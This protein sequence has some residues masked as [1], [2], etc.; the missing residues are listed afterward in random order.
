MSIHTVAIAVVALGTG[1]ALWGAQAPQLPD[2]PGKEQMVAV[3]GR[4]HEAQ[5]SASLRLSREGWEKVMSDMVA[6]GAAMSPAEQSA[7]LEYLAT[8]L[9]GE[10]D[11]PLNINTA[12]NID[13]EAVA[14][15]TRTESAALREWLKANGACKSL[16]DLKKAPIDYKKI[17]ERKEYLLCALALK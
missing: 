11:Q 4:C 6:R 13:L 7:V 2:G 12:T 15:L 10:A 9:L 16:E 3:C 5:R 17:E 14:G 8:Q 1:A